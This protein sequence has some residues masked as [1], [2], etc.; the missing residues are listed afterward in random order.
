MTRVSTKQVGVLLED[1]TMSL[2]SKI[3]GDQVKTH[4]FQPLATDIVKKCG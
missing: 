4:D 3:V 2:F 1:E